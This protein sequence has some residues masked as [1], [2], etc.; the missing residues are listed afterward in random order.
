[1]GVIRSDDLVKHSKYLMKNMYEDL[2]ARSHQG[3]LEIVPAIEHYL[4][5]F[6]LSQA[7]CRILASK[8]TNYNC[9]N[10]TN[11][12]G[13]SLLWDLNCSQWTLN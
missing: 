12:D 13:S 9:W 1:M 8:Y 3:K 5:G 2:E 11:F 4:A 10:L 7:R 6:L